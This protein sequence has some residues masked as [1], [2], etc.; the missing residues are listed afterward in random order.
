[1]RGLA[2]LALVA[3][4]FALTGAAF[5]FDNGQYDN[6]PPTFVLGSKA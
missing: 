4:A 5:G 6:V 1:M 3:C 2:R